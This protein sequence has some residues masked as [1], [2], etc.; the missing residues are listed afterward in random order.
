MTITFEQACEVLEIDITNISYSNLTGEYVKKQYH[1]LALKYH[2]DK[3]KGNLDSLE[4][5]KQIN[6]AYRFLNETELLNLNTNVREKGNKVYMSLLTTFIMDIIKGDYK[7]TIAAIIKEIILGYKKI[8]IKLFNQI[9]KQTS[10]EIYSF[11]KKYKHI[12]YLSDTIVEQVRLIILEKYQ[13]DKIYILNPG[14]DDLLDNNLYKL[15]DDG[16]LY[17]VPLW[18]KEVFFDDKDGNEIIVLCEPELPEDITIDDNKNVYK[19]IHIVKD[20]L[21]NNNAISF[22]VG[23]KVFEI[24]VH[25]L[26][27]KKHQF[28]VLKGKGISIGNDMYEDSPRSDIICQIC[29]V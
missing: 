11:L 9:D 13:N 28:Y 29:I 27:I 16:E 7:D 20:E 15:Q 21:F 12:L 22:T 24:P 2:P 18:F 19:T 6:E 4:R 25:K 23:K 17:L 5:F 1:K 8:S 14:I 26:Y 10:L 3:T